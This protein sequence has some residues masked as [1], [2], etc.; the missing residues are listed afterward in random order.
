MELVL[1]LPYRIFLASLYMRFFTDFHPRSKYQILSNPYSTVQ[2]D[3]ILPL[4]ETFDLVVQIFQFN[5]I[6]IFSMHLLGLYL[7]SSE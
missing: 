5:T 4:V 2:L 7:R 6:S 3:K 1:P